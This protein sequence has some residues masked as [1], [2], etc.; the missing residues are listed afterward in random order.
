MASNSGMG[1]LAFEI[2]K[3]TE[4]SQRRQQ[5]REREQEIAKIC[6]RT[7]ERDHQREQLMAEERLKSKDIDNQR[8]QLLAEE[9]SKSREKEEELSKNRLNY[10]KIS[11]VRH[12]GGGVRVR[13]GTDKG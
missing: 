10:I 2:S 8:E 4:L 11:M 9:R 13:V 1:Q 12:K 6:M 7:K 3:E 5:E